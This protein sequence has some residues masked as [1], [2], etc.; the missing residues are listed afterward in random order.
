MITQ[1]VSPSD[2]Q[3]VSQ[4]VSQSINHFLILFFNAD[5]IKGG[6]TGNDVFISFSS[7]D[8]T[9]VTENLIPLLEKHSISYSVRPKHGGQ[10]VQQSPC[11]DC[12]V[13]QLPRQ[14]LLP[15]RA[16][17]GH[18]EGDRCGRFVSDTCDD[19]EVQEKALA[20]RF[21]EKEFSGF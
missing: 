14:Q 6:I 9:W 12:F 20:S 19:R 17:H 2:S 13:Q 11:A 16:A 21:E 18:S 3:S 1:L 15:G 10:C 5:K 4:S 8:V 7:K